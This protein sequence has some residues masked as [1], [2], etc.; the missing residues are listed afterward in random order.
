MTGLIQRVSRAEVW[1]NEK[2]I[3]CIKKGILLLVG[4]ATDDGPEDVAYL[5]NKT[6][7][8]RIFSDKKGN[9][10]KSLLDVNGEIL[11]VSQFTLLGDTRKGRRPSFTYAAPTEEAEI[12]YRSLIEKLKVFQIIVKEGVYGEMMEVKLTNNGPVTLI[13]NSKEKTWK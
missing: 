11:V 7:H 5:V 13:I 10:N 2:C 8:L 9:L 4:I 1:V 12:I 6:V 3:S